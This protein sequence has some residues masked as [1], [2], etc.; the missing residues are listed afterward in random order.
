M[1]IK[2]HIKLSLP[3][4]APPPR[5]SRA[6]LV[7]WSGAVCLVAASLFV[8]AGPG[9]RQVQ[10]ASFETAVR[11]NAA[12]LQLA[13]ESYAAAHQGSYPDDP[14]DLLPWLPGDRPPV[15]PVDG[16][17][18]RFRDEPGDV[19][20]R[21]PTHG[22]DYVIE[23]WGRRAALGPPVIVLSGQARFN[24]SASHTD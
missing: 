3:K 7:L 23:G 21:S 22:R 11:T 15:N 1:G 10:K 5:P 14:H 6:D 2:L 24:L 18:L 17:P 16:E 8:F 12:T 20:Y 13:A 19:T 9:L 4:P